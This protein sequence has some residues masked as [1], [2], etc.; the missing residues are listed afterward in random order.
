M[1]KNGR[2]LRRDASVDLAT[3]IGRKRQER[4]VGEPQFSCSPNQPLTIALRTRYPMTAVVLATSVTDVSP[5]IAFRFGVLSYLVK[6]FDLSA[7][8]TALAS[9]VE[10]HQNTVASGPDSVE[11][12]QLEK[13][14]DSLEIL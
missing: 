8:L 10:W 6:P 2:E 1:T 13:W 14:V 12:D 3:N 7:V 11:A 9:A 4:E 5:T